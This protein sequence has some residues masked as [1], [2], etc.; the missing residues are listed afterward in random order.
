MYLKDTMKQAFSKTH[1]HTHNDNQ[2]NSWEG[3][4]KD[5]ADK[6][7]ANK[8]QSNRQTSKQTNNNNRNNNNSNNN[9][10][11]IHIRPKTTTT[12]ISEK[13]K[14][15]SNYHNSNTKQKREVSISS[16]FFSCFGGELRPPTPAPLFSLPLAILPSLSFF[17]LYLF[18]MLLIFS[19]C[20][21]FRTKTEPNIENPTNHTTNNNSQKNTLTPAKTHKIADQ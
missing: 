2:N 16:L 18:R 21:T 17:W 19:S 7:Q 20:P 3:E 6:Q 12:T 8:Q 9:D 4:K 13:I 14:N 10:K 11:N 5:K 15:S 1:K